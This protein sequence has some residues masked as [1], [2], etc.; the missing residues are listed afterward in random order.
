MGMILIL[1][2]DLLHRI[3][4]G[5]RL[6]RRPIQRKEEGLVPD[7]DPVSGQ[8][9]IVDLDDEVSAISGTEADSLGLL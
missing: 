1:A 7:I 9:L 2:R 8:E 5:V 4:S 3:S 6:S